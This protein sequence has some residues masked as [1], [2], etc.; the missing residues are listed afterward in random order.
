MC[1]TIFWPQT[2]I[3]PV[4]YFN[5][6]SCLLRKNTKILAKGW[7]TQT[8][9]VLPKCDRYR[10]SVMTQTVRD[11]LQLGRLSLPEADPPLDLLLPHNQ[12][13]HVHPQPVSSLGHHPAPADIHPFLP[14][15]PL[16]TDML[17]TNKHV[18]IY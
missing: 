17:N 15:L 3:S 5:T 1:N 16:L 7:A 10:L 9:S 4:Q 13:T 12:L 11:S 6:L 8:K 2:P 14:T 18:S